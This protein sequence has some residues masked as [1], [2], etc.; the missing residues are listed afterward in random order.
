LR[1]V[2]VAARVLGV[3]L[4]I[5]NASSRGDIEDAFTALVQQRAGALLV[6]ADPLFASQSGLLVT[7]AAHHA[8][9]RY[10]WRRQF[11][12]AGGL[13]S[14]GASTADSLR[15]MRAAFSRVRSPTT[16]QSS[17]N[18]IYIRKVEKVAGHAQNIEVEKY[19]N[20]KDPV[21]ALSN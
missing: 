7:L 3:Q 10:Y 20:V 17:S 14:Y 6:A 12:E 13:I 8:L 16:C 19:E 11:V 1:E 4:L 9:P 18:T 2:Q 15:A 21:K 5:L